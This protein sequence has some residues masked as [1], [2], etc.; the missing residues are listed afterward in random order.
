[1]FRD[2][3][4]AARALRALLGTLG[5]EDIWSE[6]GPSQSAVAL[7]RDEGRS[8]SPPQALLLEAAFAF[9]ERA[10]PARVRLDEVIRVLD[11]RTSEALFSLV[12]AYQGGPEAVDAWLAA[13]PCGRSPAALAS[14]APA[15]PSVGGA[16]IIDD[17]GKDWPSLDELSLRYI[18]AV[19]D[20]AR[21][22]QTRAAEVLGIDRR[23]LS[24]VLAKVRS[25]RLPAMQTRR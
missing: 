4:Q 7:R 22:N 25:G 23:T 10:A 11:R 15:A 12:I 19:I 13:A 1:V 6:R 9:W 8:L 20:R 14:T 24:R 21:G 3:A 18:R 2:D 17:L 16:A 5:L